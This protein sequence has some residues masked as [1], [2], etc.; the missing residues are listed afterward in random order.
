MLPNFGFHWKLLGWTFNTSSDSQKFLYW[1][2]LLSSWIFSCV[3]VL[4]WFYRSL[5]LNKRLCCRTFWCLIN[6]TEWFYSE[7][8]LFYVQ[9]YKLRVNETYN[10]ENIRP[11]IS[12]TAA[13]RA[14]NGVE[15]SI[16][17]EFLKVKIELCV[18]NEVSNLVWRYT[19]WRQTDVMVGV[20][21]TTLCSVNKNSIFPHVVHTHSHGVPLK[22]VKL[23]SS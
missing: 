9:I 13:F 12:Y 23:E 10:W 4:Q 8:F 18:L 2:A 3:Q 14:S 7:T 11:T 17:L 22:Y 20:S 16:F 1:H 6:Y 15:R 5:V 21:G 19:H